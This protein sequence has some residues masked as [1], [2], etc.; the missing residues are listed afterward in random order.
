MQK[1]NKFVSTKVGNLIVKVTIEGQNNKQPKQNNDEKS[2]C[3][4]SFSANR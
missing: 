3:N 1:V 4:F 2:N